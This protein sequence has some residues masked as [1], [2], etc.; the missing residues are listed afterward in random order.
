MI[1]P[2][3]GRDDPQ[4]RAWFEGERVIVNQMI[5]RVNQRRDDLKNLSAALDREHAALERY[6][7]A[8]DRQQEVLEAWSRSLR[9]LACAVCAGLGVVGCGAVVLALSCRKR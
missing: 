4:L 7:K 9:G 8:L 6:S 1:A 3:F 5:E 2:V